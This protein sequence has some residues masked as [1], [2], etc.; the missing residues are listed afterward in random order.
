MTDEELQLELVRISNMDHNQIQLKA[1]NH[2]HARHLTKQQFN[3]LGGA[4]NSRLNDYGLE[5]QPA[6]CGR[7]NVVKSNGDTINVRKSN[8]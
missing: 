5:L 6:C 4:I 7:F 3:M 2:H 8:E 1:R